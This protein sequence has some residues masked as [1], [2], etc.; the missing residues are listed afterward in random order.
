MMAFL[1]LLPFAQA[2][3]L[4]ARLTTPSGEVKS[5]TFHDVESSPP[6]AFTV[7]MNGAE[8]RVE[9]R[10]AHEDPTWVVSAELSHVDKKGRA[11]AFCSPQITVNP[12][13]T[14]TVKQGARIPV[15]RTDPLEY[16][17]E[18]WQLEVTVRPS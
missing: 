13:E 9:L 8:V 6:P 12:N 11:K 15:P 18:S 5:L 3:D 7:Q 10:V 4:D 2:T 14:G 17:E 16:R 1:A